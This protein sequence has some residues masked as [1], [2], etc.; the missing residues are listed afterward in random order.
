MERN[1]IKISKK[2]EDDYR[3]I[4]VRLKLG[5]FEAIEDIASQANRSRNDVINILL[6]NAV[7]NAEI[8]DSYEFL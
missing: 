6:G 4:S 2:G 3:T 5:T 7:K 1:K 8:E